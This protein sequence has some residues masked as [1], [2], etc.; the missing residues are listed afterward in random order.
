MA[1]RKTRKFNVVLT[2]TVEI[3][4]AQG[5]LDGVLTD[6]WRSHFYKFYRPEEVA[7]NL[8]YN[9]VANLVNDVSSLDGFADRQ[10]KD[11]SFGRVEWDDADVTEIK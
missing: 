4:V 8:A 1:K 10:P 6:E 3:E 9:H 7:G 11:A 5:L 2:A